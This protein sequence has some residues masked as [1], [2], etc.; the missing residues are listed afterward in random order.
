[1][2]EAARELADLSSA[3]LTALLEEGD[4]T[5]VSA[6][7]A[8]LSR[9]GE[10]SPAGLAAYR[11]VVDPRAK[12]TLEALTQRGDTT[13]LAREAMRLAHAT[14]GLRLLTTL[15]DVRTARGDLDGAARVLEDLLRMR[16]GSDASAGVPR[17]VLVSR[18]AALRAAVGD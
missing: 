7:E 18:L 17:T 13:N 12:S 4:G 11:A 6:E 1:D 3:D 16:V 8:V 14:D 15:A 9:V 10:L 2:E 5:Y